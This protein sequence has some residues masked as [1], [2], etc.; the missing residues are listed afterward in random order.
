MIIIAHC[1]TCNFEGYINGRA[2][3]QELCP[4]CYSQ[5]SLKAGKR[6]ESKF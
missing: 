1:E 5:G 4:V 3:S 2:L 6:K